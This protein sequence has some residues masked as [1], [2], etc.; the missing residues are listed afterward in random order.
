MLG[1]QAYE[2]SAAG[3]SDHPMSPEHKPFSMDPSS[4]Q[5]VHYQEEEYWCS[6]AY[7]ELNV[8]VGEVF[9]VHNYNKVVSIDGFTNPGAKSNRFC[10]GQLSNVNRNAMI[11]STRRHIGQGKKFSKISF[12]N[13]V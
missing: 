7:Y 5:P 4:M 11:E 6:F 8:R 13:Q 2:A 1:S 3:R 12:L 10:L 9:K